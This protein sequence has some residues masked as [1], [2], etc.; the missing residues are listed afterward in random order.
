MYFLKKK[1]EKENK[2]RG[3]KPL[4]IVARKFGPYR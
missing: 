3:D 2:K 4:G 1:K